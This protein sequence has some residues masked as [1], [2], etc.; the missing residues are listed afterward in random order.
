MESPWAL[1]NGH[2]SG[3]CKRAWRFSGPRWMSGGEG[4]VIGLCSSYQEHMTSILWLVLWCYCQWLQMT[5]LIFLYSGH[6]ANL[7]FLLL[8]ILSLTPARFIS[9]HLCKPHVVFT[10]FSLCYLVAKLFM[11]SNMHVCFTVCWTPAACCSQIFSGMDEQY[12][13]PQCHRSPEDVVLVNPLREECLSP[14]VTSNPCVLDMEWAPASSVWPRLHMLDVIPWT[15]V[16]FLLPTACPHCFFH[17]A[18][19]QL[20]WYHSL[21]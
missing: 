11:S 7:S 4:L 1:W 17:V 9:Y 14:W 13:S 16:R 20:S 18:N 6:S 10:L 19:I 5:S 21:Q 3:L 12:T 15:C 2:D 8:Y